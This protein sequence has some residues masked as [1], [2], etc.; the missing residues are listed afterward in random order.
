M[1]VEGPVQ[2]TLCPPQIPDDLAWDRTL[3]SVMKGGY[4]Q[5]ETRHGFS[6]KQG[7]TNRLCIL[8]LLKFCTRFAQVNVTGMAHKYALTVTQQGLHIDLR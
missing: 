6:Y 3:A 8:L 5:S 1:L 2:T 7:M 4:Y